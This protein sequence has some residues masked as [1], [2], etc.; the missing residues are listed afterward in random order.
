MLAVS[1]AREVAGCDPERELRIGAGEHEMH[2]NYL[3]SNISSDGSDTI[4]FQSRIDSAARAFGA[5]SK[6]IFRS[7]NIDR[8]AKSAIYESLI[9]SIC[10][11]ES[12]WLVPYR[13]A[14]LQAS[15]ISR[16]MC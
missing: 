7:Q 5:L 8:K 16:S 11:Y 4:E 12:W 2:I 9:L 6:C 15:P 13:K 3:G 10:L 1:G 14:V